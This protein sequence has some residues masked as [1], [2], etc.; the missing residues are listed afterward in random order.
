MAGII[1]FFDILGYQSFL[2][3]NSA[4]ES[5]L[6]T[7]KIITDLPEQVEKEVV[8][9]W[10]KNESGRGKVA[11]EIAKACKHLIFSDTIV[12]SIEYPDNADE[13]WKL[14]ALAYLSIFSARLY[15]NMFF[16]GLPMRGVIGEGDF[17]FVE[18]CLAGRAV[19]DTYKLCQSMDVAGVIF[20]DSLLISLSKAVKENERDRF[21]VPHMT[22]FNRGSDEKHF[23]HLNWLGFFDPR[24]Q[25][26]IRA[27]IEMFVLRAFLG[28]K[29]DC[30]LEVDSKIHNTN[31][32]I[33][34]LFI[35]ID[36]HEAKA[37]AG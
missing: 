9:Q 32:L 4:P 34:R 17:V 36:D 24:N 12:L 1:A 10:M 26:E 15:L 31:K 30:R 25:L 35:A 37:K 20:Q 16:S 28:H 5:A 11:E 2:E 3:N 21:F 33:R 8:E 22:S 27:D 6:S 18:T 23:V 19:V 29:K 13:N 14:T 7:L